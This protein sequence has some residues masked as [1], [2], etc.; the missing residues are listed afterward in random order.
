MNAWYVGESGVAIYLAV[1]HTVHAARAFGQGTLIF[2][3]RKV[4]VRHSF[5]A[6][7]L[8]FNEQVKSILLTVVISIPALS[9][10]LKIIELGGKYFYVYVWAFCFGFSI[11]MLTIVPV[12]I[13]PLFN[14]YSPLE[15]FIGAGLLRAKTGSCVRRGWE[16]VTRMHP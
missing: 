10:V 13:M 1:Q 2:E 3:R 5:N 12:V 14:T 6:A 11:F 16:R 8:V 4:L 15:V 7:R 9:C